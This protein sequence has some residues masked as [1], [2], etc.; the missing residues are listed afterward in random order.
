MANFFVG[1]DIGTSGTKSCVMDEQGNVLGSQYIEYKLY[2]PR[3]SWAEHNPEDYWN[4][5]ADTIKASIRKANVDPAEI[6]GVSIS[7][8]SPGCILVD[9][10]LNPPAV[11]PHLDGPPRREADRVDPRAHRR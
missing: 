9:K 5:A 7:A 2:T 10:D 8:L 3:P 4:A 11:Q 1:C 6:R